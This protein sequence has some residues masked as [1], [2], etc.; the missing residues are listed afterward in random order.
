[1]AAYEGQEVPLP[2]SVSR[3]QRDHPHG[4]VINPPQ[5]AEPELYIKLVSDD[6]E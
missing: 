3:R 2:C 5:P 1:M 6:D 4:V